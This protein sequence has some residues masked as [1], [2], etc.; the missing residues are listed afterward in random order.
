MLPLLR[1]FI[2]IAALFRIIDAVKT[3]DEI[4]VISAGGPAGASQ[5]L[6]VLA[7]KNA[8]SFLSFGTAAAIC[9]LMFAI[10]LVGSLLIGQYRGTAH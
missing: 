8:F 1:P 4:Q 10:A 9:T 2:G 3:F 6:Y 5:T 7:Y